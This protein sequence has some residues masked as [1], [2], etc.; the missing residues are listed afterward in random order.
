MEKDWIPQHMKGT[1]K[2][3]QTFKGKSG[4]LRAVVNKAST[5]KQQQ[6]VKVQSIKHLRNLKF[7]G[8]N[9]AGG[10]PR[11]RR[12]SVSLPRLKG[13]PEVEEVM[14]TYVP[15]DDGAGTKLIDKINRTRTGERPVIPEC[16]IRD[17]ERKLQERQ[18]K[19][20]EEANK[21]EAGSKEKLN[22][23]HARF[24]A[25]QESL[26]D[27]AAKCKE[28]QDKAFLDGVASKTFSHKRE[29][30]LQR[31]AQLAEREERKA[32]WAKNIC[33]ACTMNVLHGVVQECRV[34]RQLRRKHEASTSIAQGWHRK[35]LHK[36]RNSGSDM[37]QDLLKNRQQSHM[38]LWKLQVF[39][40][41]VIVVQ[42]EW[43]KKQ[44][45]LDAQVDLLAI[46]WAKVDQTRI[47]K[48][49]MA[50]TKKDERWVESENER[51]AKYNQQ[52]TGRVAGAQAVAKMLPVV[53]FPLEKIFKQI[54]Y[55]GN[56]KIR[57]ILWGSIISREMHYFTEWIAYERSV[58][59]PEFLELYRQENVHIPRS[60]ILP[61]CQRMR[62]NGEMKTFLEGEGMEFEVQPFKMIP[63][64]Q[65]F[66]KF[67]QD[68]AKKVEPELGPRKSLIPIRKGRPSMDQMSGRTDTRGG[69]RLVSRAKR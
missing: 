39:K 50:Y 19:E 41:K 65:D 45:R 63:T 3:P 44:E 8:Q 36:A 26:R 32:Q 17:Q 16:F 9:G 57:V 43:R 67:I 46:L 47:E 2:T 53:T 6:D 34:L 37:I 20:I 11:T 38:V 13:E 12:T 28:E 42:R 54:P 23:R 61:K 22:K 55:F 60:E 7:N 58:L 31:D 51:I 25:E 21:A 4:V 27:R 49:V 40:K 64:K 10:A 33:L 14:M 48:D 35:A 29:V 69:K 1:Q 18:R 56:G 15:Y 59:W 68:E 66:L 52:H 30:R 5:Q 24:L 62:R